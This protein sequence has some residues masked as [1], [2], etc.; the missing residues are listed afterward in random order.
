MTLTCEAENYHPHLP[1]A[2][3]K[4]GRFYD[5]GHAPGGFILNVTLEVLY[6]LGMQEDSI[7][8]LQGE[9]HCEVW[10]RKGTFRAKS[11]PATIRFE[12]KP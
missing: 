12:G 2:W 9:Y 7:H 1:V 3:V 4:D 11:R 6:A 5:N 10:D 8:S